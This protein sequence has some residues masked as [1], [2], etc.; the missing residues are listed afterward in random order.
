MNKDKTKKYVYY[1]MM[2]FE[3]E[4]FPKS[5]KKK[6]AEK[7]ADAKSLGTSLAEESLEKIKGRLAK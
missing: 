1:S 7:S 6:M 2:E 5:F 3:R 4:F